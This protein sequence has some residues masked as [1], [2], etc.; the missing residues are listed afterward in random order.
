M[1]APLRTR[2]RREARAAP[3][4]FA[5]R[6][7]QAGE[8]FLHEFLAGKHTDG[9]GEV[10]E[11]F[12]QYACRG[13]MMR[14]LLVVLAYRMGRPGPLSRDVLRCA[15]ALEL[16]HSAMLI[17]DD[18]ID[19]SDTRRG[20]PAWHVSYA[21]CAALW[22]A[23]D[24]AH[25][26]RSMAL[27]AGDVGFFLAFEL[28]A[29]IGAD[30]ATKCELLTLVSRTA[31]TAG[32]GELN[33][34]QLA[35]HHRCDD[36]A[37]LDVYAKKTAGYSCALP[38]TAGGLLGGLAA[39]TVAEL[40]AVGRELG[41]IFQIIDDELDLFGD[42]QEM[43]KPVGTDVREGRHTLYYALLSRHL[44]AQEWA[45]IGSLFGDR[46]LRPD[47]LLQV[48]RA[49]DAAGIRRMVGSHLQR[50]AAG[51]RRRVEKLAVAPQDR[52]ALQRMIGAVLA[53]R[54]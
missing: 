12:A 23:A 20:L 35:L 22:D 41:Q 47:D 7:R 29:Q 15:A 51:I 1:P 4:P 3:V 49:I 25:V 53:R 6:D 36:D 13:K 45:R 50:T 37:I 2:P 28:L 32:E 46:N 43:G 11:R 21:R 39:A 14:A 27:C 54:P 33:E 40:A 9:A 52:E 42:P 10:A 18:I 38:L 48:R 26:G 19:R 31:G 34:M 30:P 8:Q 16:L 44:P 17:H 5:A 24:A